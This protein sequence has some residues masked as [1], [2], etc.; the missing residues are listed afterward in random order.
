MENE[1]E[2]RKTGYYPFGYLAISQVDR[3]LLGLEFTA[4]SD[5]NID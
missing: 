2:K 4:Y 3:R 5:A 1:I